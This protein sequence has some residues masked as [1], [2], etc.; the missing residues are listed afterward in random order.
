MAL[1]ACASCQSVTRQEDQEGG[2]IEILGTGL[3]TELTKPDKQRARRRGS[4][5]AQ[6]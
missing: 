6:I 4:T 2:S 3:D 5:E 1:R